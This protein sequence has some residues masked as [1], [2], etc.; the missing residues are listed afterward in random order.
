MWEQKW[1]TS[2]GWHLELGVHR[3]PAEVQ[4]ICR[5]VLRHRILSQFVTHHYCSIADSDKEKYKKNFS[6]LGVLCTLASTVLLSSLWILHLMSGRPDTDYLLSRQL[7][8]VA[9]RIGRPSKSKDL[10]NRNC[11]NQWAKQLSGI[12]H[13]NKVYFWL[14]WRKFLLPELTIFQALLPG[15]QGQLSLPSLP[16]EL[17]VMK[18]KDG[19]DF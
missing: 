5:S 10:C 15:K 19:Q 6:F 3:S 7:P 18:N 13:F 9:L 14:R 11:T 1:I 16:S 8:L 2:T 17:S 12:L 4:P